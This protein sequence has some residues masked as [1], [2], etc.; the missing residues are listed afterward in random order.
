MLDWGETG[1]VNLAPST[2]AIN[3]QTHILKLDVTHDFDDWHL[4]DNARVE[5]YT[6]N[7]RS[8]ETGT[9]LGGAPVT[10]DNYHHVQGMNT[11]TLQKQIR[12]WWFL[13]GGGYYSQLEGSDFFNKT[14]GAFGFSWNSQEITLRRQ[15]EIFSLTSL[16]TPLAYLS[17]SVGTQNEW[18]REEGF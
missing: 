12:D 17:F 10:Q 6:E 7:N 18:T 9:F 14:N 5:F 4:E 8:D 13:S 3:E 2:K 15:S 1:G 16:F 11:L